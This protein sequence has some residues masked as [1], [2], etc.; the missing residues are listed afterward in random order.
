[1]SVPKPEVGLVIRYGYLWKEEQGQGK[2]EGKDRPA[3]IVS[4]MSPTPGT[5][6]VAV[7]PIMHATPSKELASLSVEIP[8]PVKQHLGLDD[9]S[10]WIRLNEVNQFDWP[11]PDLRQL[12]GK[13]GVFAY[14]LLPPNF[15]Q[16]VS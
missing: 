13:P 8:A 7:L 15:Y 5:S 14:G 9:D 3:V 2:L 6:R 1:M 12:T 10:S 11:G 16:A 4:A